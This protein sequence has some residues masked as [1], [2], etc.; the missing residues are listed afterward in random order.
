M[1]KNIIGGLFIAV[2]L[3][4]TSVVNPLAAVAQDKQPSA[5]QAA[6]KTVRPYPFR[7]KVG[8]I[9]KEKK[10]ITILG[11]EKGRVLYLSDKTKIVKGGKPAKLEDAAVGDQIAGRLSKTSDG[12]EMLVSLRIGPKPASTKHQKEKP[13]KSETN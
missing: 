1:K 9:D 6:S 2:L 8:A 5:E 11:K 10:T 13:D 7:G 3:A 12:K 4:A